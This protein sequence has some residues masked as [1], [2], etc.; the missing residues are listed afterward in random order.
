MRYTTFE[1]G[2]QEYKLRLT[3]QTST[4]LERKLG[5]NPLSLITSDNFPPLTDVLLTLHAAMQKFH[6]GVTMQKVFDLYDEYVESGKDYTD[7][8]PM[9]ADVLEV[10]GFLKSTPKESE[11]TLE[12]NGKK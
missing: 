9:L 10:S 3:A 1:F 6:H 7:L 5:R 8:I 4:E 2:N 11:A 12:D